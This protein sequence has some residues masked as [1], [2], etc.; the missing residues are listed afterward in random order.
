MRHYELRTAT[1]PRKRRTEALL[2]PNRRAMADL[3]RP[4]AESCRTVS[5]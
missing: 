4:V 1:A 5:A 3:L 2:I